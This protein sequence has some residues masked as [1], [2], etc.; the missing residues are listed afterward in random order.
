V[1]P[2]LKDKGWAPAGRR[3]LLAKLQSRVASFDGKL[4]ISVDLATDL[5]LTGPDGRLPIA[6]RPGVTGALTGT[7]SRARVEHVFDV[8]ADAVSLTA[9][10]NFSGAVTYAGKRARYARQAT[11]GSGGIKLCG[12]TNSINL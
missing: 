8:A 2:Y 10:F 9:S 1:L 12:S 11:S 5:T 4:T 7:A 6:D 3:W